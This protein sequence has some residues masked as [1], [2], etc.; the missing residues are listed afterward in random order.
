M[1]KEELDGDR[2]F[3]IHDFLSP[4][5]C[6][7]LIALS[8]GLAWETGTLGAEVLEQYRNNERVLFDHPVLAAELF[9]RARPFL[10]GA[11]DGRI[12]S[13]FNER[14]RYYRYGAGQAFKPHRDGSFIRIETG[15]ES[16]LTF[17]VYLN[18]EARGG[19]TRFFTDMANAFQGGPYL[20]VTP[21][22]GMALV[23]RHRVWHEGAV[24]EAGEKYVLRTD[25]MFAIPTGGG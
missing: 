2:V 18:E 10:P 9:D 25:V 13:G 3:V 6:A 4:S 11:L 22:A 17:M 1:T 7:E 19:Q 14:W 21:R 23:F 24:V 20:T 12:L 16:Y 5:E 8:T 15:E